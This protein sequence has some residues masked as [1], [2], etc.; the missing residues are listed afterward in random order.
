[1]IIVNIFHL[2]PRLAPMVI[3]LEL[4][5]TTLSKLYFPTWGTGFLPVTFFSA[6][7]TN[8]SALFLENEYLIIEGDI[9]SLASSALYVWGEGSFVLI[10]F[11]ASSSF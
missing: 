10:C 4:K 7:S 1:M 5:L 9:F 2:Y 11:L 3:L 8:D 6:L